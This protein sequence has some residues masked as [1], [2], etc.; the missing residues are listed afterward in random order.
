MRHWKN[1]VAGAALTL[2]AVSLAFAVRGAAKAARESGQ[3]SLLQQA[4]QQLSRYYAEHGAYPESLAGF[5]F[6]FHDGSN[7]STLDRFKYLTDGAHYRLVTPSDWDG[8]EISRCASEG[9][10]SVA[11]EAAPPRAAEP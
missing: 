8:S 6:R 5:N 10:P 9:M 7:Q 1:I 4:E 3:R 11:D 2:I